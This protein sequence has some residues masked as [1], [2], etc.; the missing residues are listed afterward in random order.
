[1]ADVFVLEAHR[2]KGLGKWL[3]EVA[4]GTPELQKVRRW[5][6]GTRDAHGL[7]RQFGFTDPE[8]G[9]LMEKLDR[10]SDC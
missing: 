3:V 2:G 10:D 5:L 8:P 7:Y 4:T 6:L 9:V 1:L